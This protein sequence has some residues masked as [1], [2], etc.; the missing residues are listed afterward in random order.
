MALLGV[1]AGYLFGFYI[2]ETYERLILYIFLPIVGYLLI[3]M[4]Q[5]LSESEYSENQTT[6]IKERCF[7][8]SY[9]VVFFSSFFTGLL[10]IGNTDWLIPHM[11]R[12]LKIPTPR[13]V[14]TGLF[15]MFATTLFY[16][17]LVGCGVQLSYSAWPTGTSLLFSTCG[18]VVIGGQFGTRLTRFRWFRDHQKHVFILLLALSMIHL[19]W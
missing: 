18:G 5:S 16:L 7:L 2:S 17:F 15:I 9:P 10:S 3:R 6:E 4:I 14:A 12:K 1:G 8:R 11:E 19:L 13:A